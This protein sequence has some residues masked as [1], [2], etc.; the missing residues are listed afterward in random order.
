MHASTGKNQLESGIYK[1]SGF[2]VALIVKSQA[3]ADS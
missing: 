3:K 1:N 2:E